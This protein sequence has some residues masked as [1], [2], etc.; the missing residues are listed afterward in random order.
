MRKQ[1]YKA[2][3][4]VAYGGDFGDGSYHD[5]IWSM[6]YSPEWND[7]ETD[8]KEALRSLRDTVKFLKDAKKQTI[9]P[10]GG[11]VEVPVTGVYVTKEEFG[12]DKNSWISADEW[13]DRYNAVKD[14]LTDEAIEDL[15]GYQF[16]R[17]DYDN[18]ADQTKKAK[19]TKTRNTEIEDFGD[20]IIVSPRQRKPRKFKRKDLLPYGVMGLLSLGAGLGFQALVKNR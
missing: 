5:R 9:I 14:K 3:R 15:I 6:V 10:G 2:L 17:Y 13:L 19:K 12:G 1:T 16:M 7:I 18:K 20:Y 11:N 8:R 4:K